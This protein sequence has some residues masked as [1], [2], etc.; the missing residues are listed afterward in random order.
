VAGQVV[1]PDG[2][3]EFLVDASQVDHQLLVDEHPHV[4]VAAEGEGL[5]GL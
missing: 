5:T 4:V 3:G 1:Q 2:R